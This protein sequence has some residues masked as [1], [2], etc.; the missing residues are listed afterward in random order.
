MLG[1][2]RNVFNCRNSNKLKSENV[3]MNN[4]FFFRMQLNQCAEQKQLSLK[5]DRLHYFV[6][7]INRLI[8]MLFIRSSQSTKLVTEF[9]TK[10]N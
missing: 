9:L 1:C 8:I 4:V 5:Y 6:R 3:R 2:V 7:S 10:A